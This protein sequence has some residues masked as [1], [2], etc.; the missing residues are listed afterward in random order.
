MP[1]M[2]VET[3]TQHLIDQVTFLTQENASLRTSLAEVQEQLEWFKRQIFGKR[4]EKIV[5][6]LD[7]VPTLFDL[8]PYETKD[9]VSPKTPIPAHERK[10]RNTSGKDSIKL[11]EDVPIERQVVD[12]SDKDKVCKETGVELVRIGEE[13]TRKLAHKPGSYYVKEIVRPK[14]ANPKKSEDG[15]CIAELPDS[16]LNRCQADESFLADII[17]KKYAD[18]L[19][20]YRQSEMLLREGISISRQTLCGWVLRS[21]E[22]LKPLYD[23]MASKII[24]SGNLFVDETPVDMQDPGKGKVAQG[25]MWVMV[26]GKD[27]NPPLRIYDFYANRKHA[28]AEK[29]IQGSVGAVLHSDKYGAYEALANA[30][31]V[32]WSPCWVHIR[33]KFIEAESGDP[34]FRDWVLRKIRYLFML[35]KVAWNRSEAERLR[36]RQDKEAPIIDE[37]IQ[38]VKGRLVDGKLLPKSKFREALCYLLGLAPHLKNYTNHP[39]ARLDNNVAERA[40]RPLAIGRKNWYFVGSEDGGKAAAI[41]LSLVQT[42]RGLGIN[43]REYLEDV[44]RRIM[45]YPAKKVHELLPDQWLKSRQTQ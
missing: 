14:Y 19:P 10:N 35:E 23:V 6:N 9:P 4:S 5:K 33:R 16:L 11:P 27:K 41:L 34:K 13:V 26:G 29:L 37:L 7:P 3:T 44:M 30:K 18:H 45:S 21:A 20:L 28:N 17:T 25:Y 22:A 8:T 39:Y 12:I 24:E 36:I 32:I 2:T 31:K 15:V 38:A 43:P 40:V 42:C 1:H